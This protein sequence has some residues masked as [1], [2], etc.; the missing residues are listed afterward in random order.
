MVVMKRLYCD[1]SGKVLTF[2]EAIFADFQRQWFHLSDLLPH[3]LRYGIFCFSSKLYGN[4]SKF[5]YNRPSV[6]F[7]IDYS[8]PAVARHFYPEFCI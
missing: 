2:Q 7:G 6:S 3:P 1:S 8:I 5:C 4:S